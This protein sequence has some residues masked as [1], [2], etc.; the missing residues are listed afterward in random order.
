VRK[1][2][3]ARRIVENG[4][5]RE[6]NSSRT[7]SIA[8]MAGL[9]ALVIFAA[10]GGAVDFGQAYVAK[11]RLQSAIDAAALAGANAYQ[12]DPDRNQAA[13]I[14]KANAFFQSALAG[15]PSATAAIAIDG[16]VGTVTI[17]AQ[18]T[19]K[20]PFLTLA[21]F[22]SLQVQSRTEATVAAALGSGH[23]VELSLMLDVTG[24]MGESAGT[25]TKL[26]AM[27]NSA[28]GLIDVL[29][30][31]SGQPRTKIALAPFS[32]TVNVGDDLAPV[33]TG[34][35][36]TKD[37]SGNTYHLKRCIIERTGAEALTDAPPAPGQFLRA[38]PN[39]SNPYVDLRSDARN[40][41]PN[42]KVQPLTRNK[43]QLK[44]QIDAYTANGVT[45]G[46][47]GTA[48][49]WYLLS[50]RWG[51]VFTGDSEPKA[52]GTTNLR[53]IA[54]LLTDGTYNT[55][56]GQQ[57]SDG[58]SQAVSIS[59]R[60]V[61][62]CSGIKAAGIEVFTIGFKLDNQLARDT[63]RDCATDQSHAFLAENADQLSAAFAD[64]AY[65]AVP[66]HLSR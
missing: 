19:I 49:A 6:F 20:T 4:I 59:Q 44:N 27:K 12:M 28:K 46:S 18:I 16:D 54:V 17:D 1:C 40:C 65:R 22:P 14:A 53:K 35:P 55:L 32:R 58:S 64:I 31:N 33:V 29:L 60:A 9:A 3:T 36:A 30:P 5:I 34:L 52:Y 11:S 47:L 15:L 63:M 42:H 7:G 39:P 13:A 10:V 37:V 45:A 25:M 57:Y 38:Y 21:G 61:N 51:G 56:D 62:I 8:P 50:P 26:Q 41:S 66:L 48:W 2:E 43:A 24:S 23:E